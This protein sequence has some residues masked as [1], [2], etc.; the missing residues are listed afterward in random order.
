[1]TKVGVELLGQLKTRESGKPSEIMLRNYIV[2]KCETCDTTIESNPTTVKCLVNFEV[3]GS[4][5]P[6]IGKSL[7]LSWAANKVNTLRGSPQ[8]LSYC[9]C[10]TNQNMQ[11]SIH[12]SC[13]KISRST[14]G[15][16]HGMRCRADLWRRHT[17]LQQSSLAKDCCM[18]AGVVIP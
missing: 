5:L 3:G 10:K 9:I 14:H 1:M 7:N 11:C 6:I 18:A 8:S 17:A 15:R 4:P 2:C 16:W 12:V 13:N